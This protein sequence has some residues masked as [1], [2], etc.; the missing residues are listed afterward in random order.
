MSRHRFHGDPERFTILADYIA[1]RYWRSIRYIAEVAGDF[2]DFGVIAF[3]NVGQQESQRTTSK[4]SGKVGLVDRIVWS[5]LPG[6]WL[7]SP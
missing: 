1:E 4:S 6:R 2:V 5:N 7:T 3:R